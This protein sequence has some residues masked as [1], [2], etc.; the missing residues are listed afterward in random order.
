MKDSAQQFV[1]SFKDSVLKDGDS[2]AAETLNY[3]LTDFMLTTCTNQGNK[4][5][6]FDGF[7]MDKSN[8]HYQFAKEYIERGLNVG[9]FVSELCKYYIHIW[10]CVLEDVTL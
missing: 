7:E 6:Y 10:K 4:R 1:N 3:L 9:L 2:V 8:A 5:Y